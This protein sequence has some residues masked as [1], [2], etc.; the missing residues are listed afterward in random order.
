MIS[1]YA[2]F[3]HMMQFRKGCSLELCSY[4][5]TVYGIMLAFRT[6]GIILV[7]GALH[8]KIVD[9]HIHNFRSHDQRC[10]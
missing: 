3:Q 1:A 7:Y 2:A 6:L 9:Y 4:D 5:L 8:G 10:T